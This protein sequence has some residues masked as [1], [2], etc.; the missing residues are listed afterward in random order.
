MWTTV[1]EGR[2][3]CFFRLFRY[4]SKTRMFTLFLNYIF[5]VSR[6]DTIREVQKFILWNFLEQF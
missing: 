4:I 2:K 6:I 5:K 1:S 3:G